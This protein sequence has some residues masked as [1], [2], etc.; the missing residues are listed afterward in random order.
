MF[1]LPL[2]TGPACSSSGWKLTGPSPQPSW[3]DDADI[4]QAPHPKVHGLSLPLIQ[5]IFSTH[6]QIPDFDFSMWRLGLICQVNVYR[7]GLLDS[8]AVN[9]TGG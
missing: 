2:Q 6:C 3:H 8:C 4:P 5:T 9:E 1:W 7:D